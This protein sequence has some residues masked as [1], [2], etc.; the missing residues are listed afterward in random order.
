MLLYLTSAASKTLDKF[1]PFLPKN[2]QETSV[3]FIPT[4]ADVYQ[5]KPWMEDDKSKLIELGFHISVIDIKNKNPQILEK[6][7][8]GV[9]IIFVAG[10]NTLYLLE[11][12]QK[13]NCQKLIRD[14]ILNGVIYIGSSAGSL[15]AGPNIEF[16]RVFADD[17]DYT[18]DL[19][20]YNGLGLV[21]FVILPHANKP[22]YLL[23]WQKII[24][25]FK[26]KYNFKTLKDSQAILIINKETQ[27]IK[28]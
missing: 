13:S 24:N 3:A 27:L 9:D 19:D 12:I 7:L 15:L 17:N 23:F 20:S 8:A 14:K 4:A 22:K 28:V 25:Q 26:D 2:P 18:A 1:I 10:G 21:D 16:E 6:E 11:Q 5:D